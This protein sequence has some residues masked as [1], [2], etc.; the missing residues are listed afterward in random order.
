MGA[1]IQELNPE[2]TF[3]PQKLL[4]EQKGISQ[5]GRPHSP[6]LSLHSLLSEAVTTVLTAALCSL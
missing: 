1:G 4:S 2:Q 5:M 3:R 6:E